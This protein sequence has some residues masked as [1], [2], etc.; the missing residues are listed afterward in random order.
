VT[1]TSTITTITTAATA[2]TTVTSTS[3]VVTT[4]PAGGLPGVPCDPAEAGNSH[5]NLGGCNNGCFCNADVDQTNAYCGRY[6]GPDGCTVCR[7]DSECPSG[8]F[9]DIADFG[10]GFR[11]DYQGVCYSFVGCTS[12][13]SPPAI[14]RNSLSFMAAMPRKGRTA[15]VAAREQ[16]H[17]M[18]TDPNR[19]ETATD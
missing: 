12:T 8:T 6:C 2:T 4:T 18:G 13:Y 1:Q 10:A 17:I 9:C 15:P 5:Y 11:G 7:S 3:T 14:K 16:A 19:P